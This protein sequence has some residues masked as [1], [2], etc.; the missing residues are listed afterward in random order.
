MSNHD[1]IDPILKSRN[2]LW[3]KLILALFVLVVFHITFFFVGWICLYF[4]VIATYLLLVFV[5]I[6]CITYIGA[7]LHRSNLLFLRTAIASISFIVVICFSLYFIGFFC[8]YS[9]T[10]SG[11]V[12]SS[13]VR[14]PLTNVKSIA[15]GPDNSIY[16]A[17]AFYCRIQV[18]DKT[19]S[20]LKSISMAFPKG[21][22]FL[23]VTD[24]GLI[25]IL[26]DGSDW[27]RTYDEYGNLV[28]KQTASLSRKS[29]PI[30]TAQNSFGDIYKLGYRDLFRVINQTSSSGET[31][32]FISDPFEL[33]LLGGLFPALPLF[34]VGLLF[35]IFL[36]IQYQAVKKKR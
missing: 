13:S 33:F 6:S 15:V 25:Q 36:C 26:D 32:T 1:L 17:T 18:F 10:T 16:C 19:G 23:H 12:F 27:Y 21:S 35:D 34:I 22:F 24:K 9:P 29:Q 11:R 2:T 31:V 8:A 7:L 20:F 30:D 4:P 3:G 14:F 5:L 28:E